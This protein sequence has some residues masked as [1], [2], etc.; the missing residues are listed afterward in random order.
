MM[1]KTPIEDLLKQCPSVYKL[2]VVAAQRA[3][4][5]ADGS[6]KFIDTDMKKVTS[7]AL[8]EIHQGKVAYKAIDEVEEGEEPKTKKRS[9][10][11]AGTRS[12]AHAGD[13]KKS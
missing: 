8:E 2:V 4:E 6:P 7:I 5:L 13:K 1:P 3:K 11:S 9:K 12:R 10:E